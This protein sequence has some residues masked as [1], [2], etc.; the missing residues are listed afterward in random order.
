[1]NNIFLYHWQ[2]CKSHFTIEEAEREENKK[3]NE[4]F[5]DISSQWRVWRKRR[6]TII[7]RFCRRGIRR[8]ENRKRKM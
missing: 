8:A 5:F 3:V 2:H 4:T 7:L 6:P 1:M